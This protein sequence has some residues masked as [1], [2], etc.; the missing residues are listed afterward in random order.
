MIKAVS[1]AAMIFLAGTM[2]AYAE[3]EA[4]AEWD[5]SVDFSRLKTYVWLPEPPERMQNQ[6]K[7]M[8][9]EPRVKSSADI[10]L[11]H[12]GYQKAEGDTADF[13]IGYQVVVAEEANTSMVNSFYGYAPAP[14]AWGRG[15]ENA[16]FDSNY[17][18]RFSRGTLILDIVDPVSGNLIWRGHASQV[19]DPDASLEDKTEIIQD[20]TEKILAS[21][22]SRD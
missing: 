22:P 9:I 5:Q 21:F 20:A 19:I 14:D 16:G 3:M 18:D 8:V 1:L 17:V 7:F 6:P 12:K 15:M 2:L 4:S 10:D 13:M 11:R